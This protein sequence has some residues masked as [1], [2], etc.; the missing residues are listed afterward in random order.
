MSLRSVGTLKETTV[1]TL[2]HPDP[3]NK[4]KKADGKPMT[5]VLHGPYSARYKKVLREQQRRVAEGMTSDSA[6]TDLDTEAFTE[7]LLIGCIDSWDIELDPGEALPF[8]E[9]TARQILTDY[10]WLFEQLK[11]V[12]GN[13]AR[14]LD[15]PSES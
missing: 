15:K 4:L 12:F 1:V 6:I 10:P 7:E 2:R 5:V 8:D 14:F 9:A 13:V 11:Q 3:R